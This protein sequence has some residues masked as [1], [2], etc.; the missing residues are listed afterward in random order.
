MIITIKLREQT[1]MPHDSA[2]HIVDMWDVYQGDILVGIYHKESDAVKYKEL[3]ERGDLDE[4]LP[5][6]P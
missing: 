1:K 3:L 4:L 2:D 5:S 6:K